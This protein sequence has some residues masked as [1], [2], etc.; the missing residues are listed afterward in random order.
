M[1]RVVPV[2]EARVPPSENSSVIV[3]GIAVSDERTKVAAPITSCTGIVTDEKI[4][5]AIVC[6][7]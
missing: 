5:F 3:E 6:V 7:P 2:A 4:S 1:V